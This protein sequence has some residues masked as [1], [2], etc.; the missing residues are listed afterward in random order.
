MR[1]RLWL[2]V[3]LACGLPA[4]APASNSVLTYHNSNLRHGAYTIH[5]LTLAAAA[6]VTPDTRFNAAL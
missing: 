2:A 4:V 5:A 3:A 6:T 1:V